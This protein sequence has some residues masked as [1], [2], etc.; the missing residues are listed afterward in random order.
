MVSGTGDLL[1]LARCDMYFRNHSSRLR[2]WDYTCPQ[3]EPFRFATGRVRATWRGLRGA[4]L[5]LS[6]WRYMDELY[7][8]N[9]GLVIALSMSSCGAS[10]PPCW[11]PDSFVLAFSFNLDLLTGVVGYGLV[12]WCAGF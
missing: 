7:A 9:V 1:R 12:S 5:A 6:Y 11:F 10:F 2:H 8:P 3:D 4:G